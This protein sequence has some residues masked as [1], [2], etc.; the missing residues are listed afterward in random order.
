MRQTSPGRGF[1]LIELLVVVSI[2]ALLIA[3][4]LPSLKSARDQAKRVACMSNQRQT[5]LT[6]QFY[7]L[8]YK[9]KVPLNHWGSTKQWNYLIRQVNSDLVQW[10]RLYAAKLLENPEIVYCPSCT[11]TPIMLNEPGN[12]W[13]PAPGKT[14][15]IGWSARPDVTTNDNRFN[16]PGGG[17]FPPDMLRLMDLSNNAIFADAFSSYPFVDGVHEGEGINATYGDGHSSWSY[18]T[19]IEQGP[20]DLDEIPL[21]FPPAA[22]INI[23]NMWLQL[24]RTF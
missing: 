23:D 11:Y 19:V 8:A 14:T 21:G 10:G 12:P 6:L 15:R 5:Y 9:G 1:T 16:P 3:I 18:R 13:P 4:L 17:L 2:I 22:S 20:M 24:D 7:A